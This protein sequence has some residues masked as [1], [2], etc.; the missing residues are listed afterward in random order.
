MNKG[1]TLVELIIYIAI[2]GLMVVS[3]ATFSIAISDS[4][5]K[6]YVVSEV[7]HNLRDPFTLMTKRARFASSVVTPTAGNSS[8]TLELDMP[9]AS[10]NLTFKVIDDIL[11]VQE[12]VGTPVAV[13]SDEVQVTELAFTNYASPGLRSNLKIEYTVEYAHEDGDPIYTYDKSIETTVRVRK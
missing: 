6:S 9:G 12:G 8:T 13:T 7:H 3:F 11:T 5:E 10:P 4:R 2:I 1:F